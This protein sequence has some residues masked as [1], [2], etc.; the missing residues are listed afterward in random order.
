MAAQQGA[1][2]RSKGK[3]LRAILIVIVAI[4]AIFLVAVSMQPNEMRVVRSATFAAPPAA[5][6]AQVNDFHK[7]GAWSPWEKL[8]PGMK[9]TYEGPTEGVGAVY[10]W[11]GNS[12]VGE[13]KM[14]I[15]ESKPNELIKIKLEFIKPFAAVNTTEFSFKPEGENTNLTWTMYGPMNFMS[16][17]MCLF[18]DM[19]K[20][21]GTDF[22]KGLAGI[23]TVVEPAKK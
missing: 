8:D 9:R 2:T 10:S 4:I 12:E 11:V 5:V 21:V 19:D 22:E 16:K 15:L 23:K 14:T 13:G 6:F 1:P 17:A 18:M 20:M 3:I 7:W